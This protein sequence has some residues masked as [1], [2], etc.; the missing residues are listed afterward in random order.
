VESRKGAK[1]GYAVGRARRRLYGKRG[2]EGN[3]IYIYRERERGEHNIYIY[4]YIYVWGVRRDMYDKYIDK[5]IY[6]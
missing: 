6:I 2:E 5:Y 4:I 1:R 3:I